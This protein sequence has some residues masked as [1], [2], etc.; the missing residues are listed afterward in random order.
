[1]R[2]NH[3]T[4]AVVVLAALVAI[5]SGRAARPQTRQP[6]KPLLQLVQT[7]PL[8]G[9]EGRI[10]HLAVD[11][12][13][14]RLFVAALGNDTVEVIDLP[15]GKR[16]ATLTGL[17]EPQGIA[18]DPGTGR[19]FVASGEGGDVRL[20]DAET[21]HLARTVP[22][23][24][25]ADNVRFDAASGRTYVGYA[26]GA[27][28]VLKEGNV[29]SRIP[30]AG[31]PE[32]FQLEKQGS[33]IFVNVPNAGHIAVVER[34]AEKVVATWPVTEARANF[35][36]ALD[37]ADHR[38]FVG[39]RNPATLVVFDTETGKLVARVEIG[40]D[41]DD[42]FWDA[43]RRQVYV[44]CG[45]GFLDVVREGQGGRYERIAHLAI[46]AGA[47]TSLFVPE[48]A[49]LYLAVP[50]RSAQGAEI[51]VYALSEAPK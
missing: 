36:M 22:L 25:D 37:E 29:L 9:V 30:L 11:V 28:A 2:L 1:V 35:P 20:F 50:H 10:D 51:R 18:V 7:L 24:D 21:L 47:R 14:G 3:P 46:A 4:A 8:P 23:G 27:L 32:S 45:A 19:V 12:K 49:R 26:G 40:G 15:V 43:K 17:R 38:L 6:P 42:L 44:S 5:G 33:R 39:C 48:F 31:H 34:K 13:R 16:N 41:T